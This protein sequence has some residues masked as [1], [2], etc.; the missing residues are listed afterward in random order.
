MK[1]ADIEDDGGAVP[2]PHHGIAYTIPC[3]MEERDAGSLGTPSL[4]L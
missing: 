2:K 4:Q 1:G 3:T